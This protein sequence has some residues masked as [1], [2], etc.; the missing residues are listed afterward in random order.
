MCVNIHKKN[1]SRDP[2]TC[3]IVH[4]KTAPLAIC[5]LSCDPV[6]R[7]L[8]HAVINKWYKFGKTG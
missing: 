6:C 4:R 8:V 1:C 2:S 7:S 5:L 3:N